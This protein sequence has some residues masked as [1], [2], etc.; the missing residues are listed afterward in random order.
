MLDSLIK[1]PFL[2]FS[3]GSLAFLKKLEDKKFNN[4]IWFDKNRDSYEKFVKLPM[5]MLI[6]D[7]AGDL[8]KIDSS[9]VVNYKSI[10]RINRD[11]RFSKDKTPYKTIT[12]ASFCFNTIKKPELPQFYFHL[13]PD[14]FLVAGGQYSMDTDKLKKIRIYIYENFDYFK[15]I[16]SIKSFAKEYIQVS[17]EKL[18]NLPRGY[19]RLKLESKNNLLIELMKMKQFYVC[20]TYN[21]EVA[22]N[23]ELVNLITY[24]FNLMYD[25]TKFLNDALI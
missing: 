19:D 9:I 10:F 7:L 2:G 20:K 25:F 17:G 5:R 23:P 3:K 22:L 14:E 18:S 24:N 13:S 4:K 12:S 8:Y 15:K 11:I 16:I 1:E 6:D 21:P